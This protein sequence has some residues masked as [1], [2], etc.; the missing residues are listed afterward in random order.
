MIIHAFLPRPLADQSTP[1]TTVRFIG[2]NRT[3]VVASD[4]WEIA[5]S[6]KGTYKDAEPYEGYFHPFDSFL[7]QQGLNLYLGTFIYYVAMVPSWAFM[8]AISF[9]S[10][11]FMTRRMGQ[12]RPLRQGQGGGQAAPANQ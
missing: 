1:A 3:S 6:G 10:R 7:A 11:S 5:S 12:D 8:I 9:F 4:I 2:L